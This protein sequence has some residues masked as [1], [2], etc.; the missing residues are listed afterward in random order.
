[1][2]GG[3]GLTYERKKRLR[4]I[5]AHRLPGDV[6]PHEVRHPLWLAGKGADLNEQVTHVRRWSH[7]Q[8]SK[9]V[10]Q[11]EQKSEKP[12]GPKWASCAPPQT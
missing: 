5:E 6:A 3:L 11:P 12:K 4:V 7:D 8:S 9:R 10:H 1:M 2:E